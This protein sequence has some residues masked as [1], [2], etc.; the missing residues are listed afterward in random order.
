MA[1]NR[2][3]PNNTQLSLFDLFS[4]NTKN[5]Q[6]ENTTSQH[7]G[8]LR[9]QPNSTSEGQ[10]RPGRDILAP[11]RQ[12]SNITTPET[13]QYEAGGDSGEL[14]DRSVNAISPANDIPYAGSYRYGA[15]NSSS[16]DST[17]SN[18]SNPGTGNNRAI[19]YL[20]TYSPNNNIAL[21][22]FSKSNAFNDN[23]KALQT[24]L[25]VNQSTSPISSDQQAAIAAYRGFGGLKDILLNPDNDEHWSGLPEI[26]RSRVRKIHQIVQ[27]LSAND[28][29]EAEK[30]L[31]SIKRSTI[32]AHFT[33]EA[34]IDGIYGII[35]KTGFNGGKILDP[36]SG[37]GRF[38][39]LLPQNIA[40]NSSITAIEIDSL[41]GQLLK[42]LLPAA[43]VHVQ[44]YERTVLPLNHFDLVI[45]NVPFAAIPIYD[46]LL[47][48]TPDRRFE[49]SANNLHNFFIAKSI[50]L[51]KPG[52]LLAF[53]TSRF[54]LDSSE[55]TEIRQIMGDYCDLLTAL[56]LPDN[57]FTAEAGTEVVSDIIILQKKL[58]PQMGN[59][60]NPILHTQTH[61]FTDQNNVS[62]EVTINNY[63]LAHPDH[64]LGIEAFSS[65]MFRENNYTVVSD[66]EDL[67]LLRQKILE[68]GGSDVPQPLFNNL[69]QPGYIPNPFEEERKFITPGQY[70][71]IGNLVQFEDGYVGRISA[72]EFNGTNDRGEVV[73]Y[74]YVD[75]VTIRKEDAKKISLFIEIRQTL[76]SLVHHEINGFS[77]DIVE[78]L[79]QKLFANYTKFT[80]LH[81]NILATANAKLLKLDLAD[82]YFISS[83]ERIDPQTKKIIPSDI[84]R[85]R[86]IVNKQDLDR[87]ENIKESI[88]LSL[89]RFGEL[90]MEYICQLLNKDLE[91][92]MKDQE[93]EDALI[94]LTPEGFYETR[95]QYLSGNVLEKLETAQELAKEDPQFRHHVKALTAIQPARIK[96]A[97]IYSP[98]HARWIPK[99]YLESFIAHATGTDTGRISIKY[100]RSAD[101]YSINIFPDTEKAALYKTARR[102]PE[103]IFEHVLNGVEPVVKYTS[104]DKVYLDEEDTL[105]AKENFRKLQML[106][107]DFKFT[108]LNRRQDL[109]EIYNRT[110]NNTVV[111]NFDGSGA[112]LKFPGLIGF[113]P[114]PHQKD[115]VFR[116]VQTLGGVLD[117]IVG[118]GKTLCQIITSMELRRLKIANKP[119]IIG[120]KAQI[121]D[122]YQ[123]FKQAYPFSKVLFPSERDFERKNRKR[124]LS[125][126][127]TND[128][129]CIILSHEQ[130]CRI[131]QNPEIQK[132]AVDEMMES[133]NAE[134]AECGDKQEIRRLEARKYRYEQKLEKLLDVSKD[135]DIL[136][137]SQLGVDFLIVDESQEFKNLEFTTRLRNVNGLGNPEGSKRAFNLMLACR[138]I[139][140]ERKGDKGILF[141][142]GTPISNSVSELYLLQKY[143]QPN[144]INRLGIDTFDKWASLYASIY[145]DLEY[146]LGQYKVVNRIRSFK[147]LQ[148]LITMY[149]E[150]A[151]VRNDSNIILDK[152]KG[153][154]QL[155]KIQPSPQQLDYI[156]K[157]FN[158]VQTK[159]NAYRHQ[160]GL[161]A[162]Y[163]SKTGRNNSAGLLAINMAKKLSLDPRLI[164]ISNEAGSKISVACENIAKIYFETTEFKGTQLVFCDL[165]TPKSTN[166]LDNL[167]DLFE[168]DVPAELGIRNLT[169]QERIDIF[170]ENYYD[171]SPKPKLAAVK[172][173]LMEIL[174]IDETQYRYCVQLANDNNNGFN[175]YSQI[176]FQLSQLGIPED[177]IAF[178]HSYNTRPQKEKIYQLV[179]DGDLRILLGSTSKLGTGTNVQRRL[180]ALHHIDI[181]WKPSQLVQRNGRGERQ[182]NWA[183]KQ[184]LDN[185]ISIF[186][187][188][189]E[190]TF[191]SYMYNLNGVKSKFID[192]LKL[193]QVFARE[194]T[195]INEEID[196]STMGAELSGNPLVKEK[197]SIEKRINE[198][199]S[200]KRS[201]Q[202]QIY[203][204][205]ENIGRYT[206]GLEYATKAISKYERVIDHVNKLPTDPE[207]HQPIVPFVVDNKTYIKPGEAGTAMLK[208][209][210]QLHERES[211]KLNHKDDYSLYQQFY[212]LGSVGGYHIMSTLNSISPTFYIADPETGE[213]IGAKRT[214]SSSEVG[215]AMQCRNTLTN[216]TEL[217]QDVKD[218]IIIQEQGLKNAKSILE[219]KFEHEEELST[220][221]NRLSEIDRQIHA[222]LDAAAQKKI[223][224]ETETESTVSEEKQAY[225][226]A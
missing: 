188:A 96:A 222:E 156:D 26:T 189:V 42:K 32:S 164:S 24:L 7:Q 121:P 39:T 202:G 61:K 150:M 36:S 205:Q 137:F 8:D 3:K 91:T 43:Q 183:A 60:N 162:G 68:V 126:I 40:K 192:Q 63:F 90:R 85:K 66:T 117:H 72:D 173:K 136:D 170:G 217:L 59:V 47:N 134:I 118:A 86:T 38:M 216:A 153:I 158:F 103:W 41:T 131:K 82:C 105:L 111:R 155:V 30:C 100:S 130:F 67:H 120:M 112:N 52:A 198:L 28:T 212:N 172:D 84:L 124:L 89:N 87:A 221:I 203:E 83:L 77:D 22:T 206:R 119:M 191:D 76:K 176:K 45:T 98:I 35:E 114:K 9:N 102:K 125:T 14:P 73:T 154:H 1:T 104:D 15:P 109:E 163:D 44:G 149:R 49:K 144:K 224:N 199:K 5:N 218:N 25:D 23:I 165:S 138:H 69:Q 4:D 56:R 50:L 51:A 101:E 88:D 219:K 184:Y 92:I 204:S 115:A 147:N 18:L 179:N 21:K 10:E 186:Y 145:S 6:D 185:Q 33:P 166:T 215:M 19:N 20:T 31:E 148:E 182:G 211:G 53:V 143:L 71:V 17:G 195:D 181:N 226:I 174:Q 108:D 37:T 139:Q 129:D 160:L 79:R 78:P 74:R 213:K 80:R 214:F 110:Y 48:R 190:R 159:G 94:F 161:T 70:D 187:Y 127:A 152:P 107:D 81:G 220:C 151:D 106:W 177:Q 13:R 99:E 141:C 58:Q 178:I 46:P 97:D 223:Q 180:S 27:E 29:R 113:T 75:P 93:N 197:A 225:R 209:K 16:P 200:L 122:L 142:S 135:T 168:G 146:Y 201:F 95:D 210:E 62:G 167:Y 171:A 132:K 11:V 194:I 54:T 128:W 12:N 196:L 207:T 193:S 175:A 133:I 57:T 55:N 123:A 157:L 140:Q 169:E 208:Y 65:G 116:T 2:Y 64:I 34:I